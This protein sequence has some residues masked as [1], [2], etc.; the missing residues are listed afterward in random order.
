M[1]LSAGFDTCSRKFVLIQIG[2]KIIAD[3]YRHAPGPVAAASTRLKTSVR[4]LD[5]SNSDL[6]ALALEALLPRTRHPAPHV[7]LVLVHARHFQSI[8]RAPF[9]LEHV[10]AEH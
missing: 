4:A 2:I 5:T 8:T 10:A 7:E 3:L 9:V 1:F 6:R